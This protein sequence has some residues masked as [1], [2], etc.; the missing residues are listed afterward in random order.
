M[1]KDLAVSEFDSLWKIY[2][3]SNYTLSQLQN[4]AYLLETSELFLQNSDFFTRSASIIFFAKILYQ[5]NSFTEF[6]SV[7][8]SQVSNYEGKS[9]AVRIRKVRKNQETKYIERELAAHFWDNYV[10]PKV[11]LDNPENLFVFVFIDE[12]NEFIVC[13]QIFE[14]EKEYLDRMPKFR[15]VKMPYTLK[16]DLARACINL[17]GLKKGLVL[18]PFAGI[19][20]ILLEAESMGFQTISNDIS[21]ND[22]K[23]LKQ[24]FDYYF[25]NSNPLRILADSRTNFLKPESIDGIVTDIPYGKCSRKLGLDLYELYLQN[26]QKY[27]KKGS[28][29]IVIYA[30]FLEFK[31]LA[32]KYFTQVQEIDQYIN[33]SMT[34]HILVLEKK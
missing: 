18:D 17:L 8:K 21:W 5:G 2:F 7:F 11:D 14:N 16:A 29:M 24:N 15:P 28:R 34:R 1:N 31:S 20:G 26:A 32:L 23:Y 3:N 6:E 4:K 22:V 13:E 19:G 9:F 10:S 12:T 33:R 30:N 27:L 25:P